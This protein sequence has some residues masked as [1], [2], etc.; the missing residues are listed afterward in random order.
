MGTTC[1]DKLTA[2]IQKI[3]GASIEDI[4]DEM[5]PKTIPNWDSMNYLI[6]M[7]EPEKEFSIQCTVTEGMEARTLGDIKKYMEKKGVFEK[8]KT[9]NV[10][11][12]NNQKNGV[13]K[14]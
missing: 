1:M 5:S 13:L 12:N 11:W 4:N 2:I 10:L 8:L 7:Y 14:I 9:S 3:F 6:V